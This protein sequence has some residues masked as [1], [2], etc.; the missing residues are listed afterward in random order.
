[1]TNPFPYNQQ[2]SAFSPTIGPFEGYTFV[3][4]TC[5]NGLSA[6][7]IKPNKGSP[8]S[9]STGDYDFNFVSQIDQNGS[10][11]TTVEFINDVNDEWQRPPYY[12]VA[13][14]AS[15]NLTLYS[16]V[17]PRNPSDLAADCITQM[18]TVI[19]LDSPV[20]SSVFCPL[21]QSLYLISKSGKLTVLAVEFES[22]FG[23]PF[24]T[25]GWMPDVQ[26]TSNPNGQIQIL[27]GAESGGQPFALVTGLCE[28]KQSALFC[29]DPEN[30]QLFPLAGTPPNSVAVAATPDMLF[31]A[32]PSQIW[33]TSI[34]TVDLS[35]P[36]PDM[37]AGSWTM[38][39][40]LP[41][42]VTLTSLAYVPMTGIPQ[43]PSGVLL[44]GGYSGTAENAASD[45]AIF[46]LDP[47]TGQCVE[48]TGCISGP[49]YG[50]LADCNEHAL[51]SDGSTGLGFLNLNA[52]Q[53]VP[54]L[55]MLVA[56]DAESH[57]TLKKI[58]K[59]ILFSI[60]VAAFWKG[61]TDMIKTL[62]QR[63][64]EAIAEAEAS[65]EGP[66]GPFHRRRER[67]KAR[68]SKRKAEGKR[69]GICGDMLDGMEDVAEVAAV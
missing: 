35:Q 26:V 17:P 34:S 25:T 43:Y 31:T 21:T 20:A 38:A 55:Q 68:R 22:D 62:K 10:S 54:P 42:S 9:D 44:A 61:T 27:L 60:L 28:G 29:I 3:V 52:A 19:T 16:F 18:S 40:A 8:E 4:A 2:V 53:G 46:L 58:A 1:M 37:F 13:G 51:F 41:S 57:G 67:K 64:E 24:F 6:G 39:A 14:S 7:V 56:N 12:F 15:N 48:L 66:G 36:T 63:R 11:N 30:C 47:A 45:G 32:T 50:L 59:G 23:I 69:K 49:V 33:S 5:A 65:K